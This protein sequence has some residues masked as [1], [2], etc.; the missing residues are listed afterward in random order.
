MKSY[1]MFLTCG[2]CTRGKL[3]NEVPQ[4]IVEK[5][6]RQMKEILKRH[7]KMRMII[8]NPVSF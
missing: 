2:L 5:K 7:F 1:P 4:S 8:K 3:T 6:T